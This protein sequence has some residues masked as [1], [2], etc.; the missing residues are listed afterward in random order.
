MCRFVQDLHNKLLRVQLVIISRHRVSDPL[1]IS[2]RYMCR[3]WPTSG[4]SRYLIKYTV[5]DHIIVCSPTCICAVRFTSC[6]YMWFDMQLKI[7]PL[8]KIVLDRECASRIGLQNVSDTNLNA[9][10]AMITCKPIS[11]AEATLSMLQISIVDKSDK[12]EFILTNPRSGRLRILR[13]PG[14][15]M[16][17]SYLSITH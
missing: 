8:G 5:R 7:E 1:T 16:A 3:S 10:S 2:F 13:R 9:I 17:L 14:N 12:V 4:F 11:V 15:E 6:P